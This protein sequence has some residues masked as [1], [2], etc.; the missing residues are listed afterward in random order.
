MSQGWRWMTA[1]L[2]SAGALCLAGCGSTRTAAL[3]GPGESLV[4]DLGSSETPRL[5]RLQRAE[6]PTL[7]V[8]TPVSA[9]GATKASVTAPPPGGAMQTSLVGPRN[10]RITIRAWVNGQPIFDDEVMQNISPSMLRALATMPEPQ[11]SEKLAEVFNQVLDQIIE[12]EV[13][14]Q[15]AVHR[16]E[17]INPKTLEKLKTLAA[18]DFEKQLNKIRE[19]GKVSE[20]QIKEFQREMRR[21]TERSFIS[22]EYMRSRIFPK[23]NISFQDIKEYYDNH[24]NEF[25]KVESVKWQDVFIAVGPKHPTLAEA[26]RFAEDLIAQ[27][28]TG[29]DFAKLS[30][31]DDGDSKFRSGEGQGSRHGEIRPAEIEAPLFK[32]KDGQIGPVV[33]LS[34]GVHIFRLVYRDP[35][36]LQPLNETV[37]AQIRTKLRNQLADREYK[38]VVRELKSRAIIEIVAAGN[39]AP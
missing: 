14:Y 29:A 3:P 8:P 30:A 1:G 20:T 9:G 23:L 21:Q 2:V 18:E 12:Q 16:L 15:D 32:L 37:Q 36:G 26:R 11:R 5:T 19:K 27:C 4:A 38:L 10:N 17:K 34:T 22:M 24:L 7:S 31:Y 39:P 33:E 6:A 25:T 35:G 28:R 13:I